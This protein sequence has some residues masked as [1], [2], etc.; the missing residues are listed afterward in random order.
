M[1]ILLSNDDGIGA[2]GFRALL[3]I[4]RRLSKDVWVCAPET[5]QSGASH[6]LT[7][8]RPLRVR[9]INRRRYVIDGTPTD[10]V[11]LAL[12]TLMRDKR[13]DLVL[14]GV[15]RGMNA[16]DDVTYSGTVAAAM[17]ATL[18]GVPAIALSQD[19]S[20]R[21]HW[22]TAETHGPPLI[23]R[24]VAAGWPRDVLINVNF[25]DAAPGAVTGIEVVRQGR[26][27]FGDAVTERLDPRG[28][29]YYWIGGER[30]DEDEAMRHK[31][32]RRGTD[33]WALGQGAIAV[34]AIAMDLTH[35]T[36][37]RRL[38]GVLATCSTSRASA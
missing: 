23:K 15:N 16:A 35:R 7:L 25:P 18:L 30:S 34:T 19:F 11:L 37:Q 4:A 38:Q 31:E 29:P 9:T 33:L 2:P 21:I 8:H 17:E 5:E 22:A 36:T 24:L 27:M 12:N 20:G 13:P 14:S 3:T 1:R 32:R 10:C 6:S 28:R 26:Y